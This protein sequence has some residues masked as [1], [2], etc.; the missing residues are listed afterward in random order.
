MRR[1]NCE[2]NFFY[3]IFLLSI[4]LWKLIYS[5]NLENLTFYWEK[6]LLLLFYVENFIFKIANLIY[7]NI[8]EGGKKDNL[9]YFYFYFIYI[10]LMGLTQ[11][12]AWK[13]LLL[14]YFI[15]FYFKSYLWN[16]FYNY[17]FIFNIETSPSGS[18]LIK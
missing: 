8:Y 14:C 9:C 2:E 4:Q 13:K 11:A 6:I 17:T 16:W 7:I 12:L 15:F 5:L 1:N 18:K 10:Y 3:F